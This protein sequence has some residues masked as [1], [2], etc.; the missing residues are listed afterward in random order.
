MY[1]L[2]IIPIA[3][4]F[5]DESYTY[6][7]NQLLNLGSLVE[8]K[9]KNRKILGLVNN[10]SLAKSQKLN[11]KTKKFTLKKIEKVIQEN[12]I[13]EIFFQSL[14]DIAILQSVKINDILSNYFPNFIYDNSKI[15]NNKDTLKSKRNRNTTNYLLED[16]TNRQNEYLKLTQ[17]EFKKNNSIVIFTPTILEVET[18]ENYFKRN[19]SNKNI[20]SFHS[21]LSNKN[22][23][24]NLKKLNSKNLFLIISTPSLF[25]ILIKDKINLETIVLD[26]EIS[27]HYLNNLI[28]KPIDFREVIKKVSLDLNLNLLI[29]GRLLT[30]NTYLEAKE[31]KVEVRNNNQKLNLKLI[32]QNKD[33]IEE[34]EIK[35]NLKILKNNQKTNSYNK[36]YFSEELIDKLE[37]LKKNSGKGFLFVKRKGLYPVT[38]CEDCQNIF[39]C[40]KCD[41]PYLLVKNKAGDKIYQ[42]QNCKEILN[43]DKNKNLICQNCNSWRMKTLGIGSEAVAKNLKEIGF[44]TFILDSDQEKTKKEILKT[45][46]D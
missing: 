34:K 44:K 45:I 18:L 6:F 37:N 32:S 35:N 13:D 42:C 1:I 36:V 25:P 10:I 2:D 43:L 38:I 7:H 21:K 46:Q 29:S 39:T 31:N 19:I 26:N 33:D 11:I 8:I 17:K 20:L 24:E 5:P 12:F 23:K 30:M 3:K 15:L 40:P 27:P 14:K 9:I 16:L 4:G 41:K 22:L 28:S